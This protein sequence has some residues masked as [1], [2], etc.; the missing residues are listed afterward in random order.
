MRINLFPFFKKLKNWA[1]DRIPRMSKKYS[2]SLIG[3]SSQILSLF[4]IHKLGLPEKTEL[5]SIVSTHLGIIFITVTYLTGQA[6]ID[7][8]ASATYGHQ[9]KSTVLTPGGAGRLG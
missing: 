8:N 1:K 5:W 4:I 7:L 2:F 9:D 6:K 3:I